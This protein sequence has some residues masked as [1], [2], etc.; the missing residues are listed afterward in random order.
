MLTFNNLCKTC[1]YGF[2]F[3]GFNRNSSERSRRSD[4]LSPFFDKASDTELARM[5]PCLQKT[6]FR[7]AVSCM[8][9][10]TPNR[11]KPVRKG[12]G[13]SEK[14]KKGCLIRQAL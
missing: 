4:G 6:Q 13:L 8:V 2:L 14:Q 12:F 10:D 11:G 1:P 5:G 3:N 9:S 7:L